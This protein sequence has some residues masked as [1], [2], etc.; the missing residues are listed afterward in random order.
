MCTVVASLPTSQKEMDTYG[1]SSTTSNAVISSLRSMFAC[2]GIPEVLWSDNGPQ[3][4]QKRLMDS[5]TTPAALAIQSNGLV[6]QMVKTVK[7]LFLHSTNLNL[8]LLTY[9]SIPLPWYN[10]SPA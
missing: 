4:P 7:Q 8:A 9:R 6:E 1:L 10:F 5:P 2:H 3:Y